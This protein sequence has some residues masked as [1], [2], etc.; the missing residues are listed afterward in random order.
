M[1]IPGL[2]K[3]GIWEKMNKVLVSGRTQM[4]GKIIG[5]GLE[6]HGRGLGGGRPG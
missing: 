1:K 5:D 2:D 6:N 4:R 3:Q